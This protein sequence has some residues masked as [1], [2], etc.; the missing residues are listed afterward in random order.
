MWWVCKC[1]EYNNHSIG[2]K[3]CKKCGGR[4]PL[5]QESS[6]SDL[7][8]EIMQ[9]LYDAFREQ[10]GYHYVDNFD[11]DKTKVNEDTCLDGTFDFTLIAQALFPIIDREKRKAVEEALDKVILS[12]IEGVKWSV[13]LI[14]E[15]KQR[16]LNTMFPSRQ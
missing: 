4:A 13:L 7:K 15:E 12:E 9:A 11:E 16:V 8:Q 10:A 14:P 5:E 3:D 6:T 2:I 1:P